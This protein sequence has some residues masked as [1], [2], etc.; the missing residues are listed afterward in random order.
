VRAREASFRAS[1]T[2][3]LDPLS[4]A[5]RAQVVVTRLIAACA[6]SFGFR[7]AWMGRLLG[8]RRG[9]ARERARLLGSL[10]LSLGP[11]LF[12]P[13]RHYPAD[14]CRGRRDDPCAH[15][16][17]ATRAVTRADAPASRARPLV[18]IKGNSEGGDWLRESERAIFLSAPPPPH[19]P[20]SGLHHAFTVPRPY[21]RRHR[22]MFARGN[23]RL[24]ALL[25]LPPAAAARRGAQRP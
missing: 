22:A 1:L 6:S 10:A 8:G 18:P 19:A 11:R 17:A 15:L 20:Q 2:R 13:P 9:A 12:R 16:G 23:R 7:G 14:R 3:S 21:A 4:P 5:R 25:P 24:R